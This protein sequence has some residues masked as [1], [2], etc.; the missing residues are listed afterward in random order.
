MIVRPVLNRVYQLCRALFARVSPSE[1]DLLQAHLTP[2]QGILFQ[3]MSRCDQRHCLDVFNALLRAGHQDDCLLQ[4]ALVHDAGKAAARLRIWHR[5]AVVLMGRFA[6]DWLLRLAANG[7]AWSKPFAVHMQH[8]ELGARWAAEAGC[9]PE[10]V[11]LIRRHHEPGFNED[12][13]A[14]LQWADRQN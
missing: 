7:R 4:A 2:A 6:P 14:A 13:L 9:S 12:A 8:A 10:M 3:R 11:S 5:V 1:Y